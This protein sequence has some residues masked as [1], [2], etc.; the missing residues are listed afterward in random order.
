MRALT[1]SLLRV[2]AVEAGDYEVLAACLQDALMP[3]AEMA[4]RPRER[5]FVA[6]FDRFMWEHCA[7]L[8]AERRPPFVVQSALR[9][10]GVLRTR[11]TGVDLTARDRLLELL[12]VAS[13]PGAL[14]LVFAGGAAIRLE[15]ERLACVVEDLAQPRPARAVPRHRLGAGGEEG[16]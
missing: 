6:V 4:F 5:R 11:S 8:T 12:T 9:V 1:P 13:E 15:G 3:L 10:E 14:V 16:A 7:P 2:R